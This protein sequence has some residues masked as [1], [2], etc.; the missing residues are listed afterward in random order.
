[1]RGSKLQQLHNSA[2][3]TD[4][5]YGPQNGKWDRLISRAIIRTILIFFFLNNIYRRYIFRSARAFA[6]T[7]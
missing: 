6:R 1:M 7:S 2:G 4:S 5:G 3:S